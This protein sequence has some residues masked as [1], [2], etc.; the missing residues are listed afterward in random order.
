MEDTPHLIYLKWIGEGAP[1]QSDADLAMRL[2]TASNHR[3]ALL[4]FAADVVQIACSATCGCVAGLVRRALQ[5]REQ[6]LI[7][8]IPISVLP[9]KM[10][11]IA[12]KRNVVQSAED[13]GNDHKAI[14]I[15]F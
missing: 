3:S 5:R 13:A 14:E 9:N 10:D 8:I 6:W 1:Q 4:D 11:N 15:V 2:T 7:R 12:Q